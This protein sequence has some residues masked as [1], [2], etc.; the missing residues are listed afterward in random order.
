MAKEKAAEQVEQVV[1]DVAYVPLKVFADTHALKY[2]IELMAG[3]FHAQERANHF[4]DTEENW[5]KLIEEFA[6]SEVK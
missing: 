6:N 1:E 3:F 5:H 2:G 4:A